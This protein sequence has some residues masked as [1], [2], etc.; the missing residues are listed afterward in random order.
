[1]RRMN[2]RLGQHTL[3][4]LGAN[5]ARGEVVVTLPLSHTHTHTSLNYNTRAKGGGTPMMCALHENTAGFTALS[6]SFSPGRPPF[7]FPLQTPNT[8]DSIMEIN[9]HWHRNKLN[10]HTCVLH[11]QY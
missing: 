7:L 9:A 8:R 6:L 3:I 1:M 11:T 10:T 4:V 2:P 5:R